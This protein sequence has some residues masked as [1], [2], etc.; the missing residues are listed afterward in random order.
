MRIDAREVLD[1]FRLL[2]IRWALLGL[3]VFTGSKVL[4]AWRWWVFLG[5]REVPLVPLAG[6]FLLSNMA[7]S[8][9]PLRAGDLLRVEVPNHRYG[10]PRSTLVS[11]VFVVES[12]LDLFAFAI[13]LVTA[14]LLSDLPV[15]MRPLVGFVGGAAVVLMGL[16][17][18]M[19]RSHDSVVPVA[20]RLLRW[21]PDRAWSWVADTLPAFV[22]GMSS[23]RTNREAVRVVVVSL[24]AWLAE[25]AVYWIL[26]HAFGLSLSVHQAL[27]LMIA[28]NLVVSLPLTPWSV[29][30][31]E[32]VVTETLV[33][34][35]ADRTEGAAFALG[36]HLMLQAWIAVTGVLAMW[37]LQLRPRD[38]LPGRHPDGP[39]AALEEAGA[40]EDLP[41]HDVG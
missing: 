10:V 18:A 40:A 26:A 27:I 3:V 17:V 15:A 2:D 7:N 5:R 21:L 25:V 32:L 6:I 41:G 35:G 36:S 34:I 33:L 11:S 9:L 30:P 12:V 19:S 31:Y 22:D 37:A 29:G 24:V 39:E 8:L 28:A 1:Q 14:L 4:H 13:L 20:S 16:M 23:L 38:L